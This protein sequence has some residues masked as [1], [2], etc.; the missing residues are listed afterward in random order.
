MDGFS[1]ERFGDQGAEFFDEYLSERPRVTDAAVNV[2]DQ[3]SSGTILE[4]GAGTGRIALPLAEMGHTVD[5]VDI[6]ERMTEM[7]RQTPGAEKLNSINV[8]DAVNSL[9][10]GPYD[11]I[12]ILFNTLLMAGPLAD[13]AHLLA[14]AAR[15]LSP[16]GIVIVEASLLNER[17]NSAAKPELRIRKLSADSVVLSAVSSNLDARTIECQNIVIKNNRI[18]L[19]P[20][21]MYV[22]TLVELDEAASRA[23]LSLLARWRTWTMEPFIDQAAKA[24]SIYLLEGAS[25][26]E[27]DKDTVS[28]CIEAQQKSRNQH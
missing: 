26:P 22:P 15:S 5:A 14:N 25:P 6:S 9:P 8:I 23:G 2:I 7:L 3:L 1:A 11:T 12:C 16:N 10:V 21:V 13:Q 19:V 20:Y 27:I 4:V 18:S 17:P 28:R 24:I